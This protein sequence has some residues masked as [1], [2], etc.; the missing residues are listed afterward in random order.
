MLFEGKTVIVTG[1]S[2]GIGLATAR[3]FKKEGA[4]VLLVA[5]SKER[6]KIIAEEIDAK[7]IAVD[8]T[9]KDAAEKIVGDTILEWNRIDV[10]VNAAGIL[11]TG[12][13]MST[14][15]EDF[16]K[17]MDV[18]L[19]SVFLLMQTAIPFLKESKGNI[20]NVSSVTGIRAFPGILSY[21][22]SKAALDHLTRCSALD[23]AP[24]GIR[25]NAVN[26]GVVVTN[27]H[28]AGGM[29]E[30]SYSNFLEHS[31]MTHPL[32]RV[33]TPD[34]VADLILFLASEKALWITGETVSIDG[35]RFLT[36]LR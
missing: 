35:G 15:V 17:M 32:G 10:L 19:R 22:V 14:P 5:R 18:N 4:N 34:E 33:G 13:I 24:F 2:S 1:A 7:Y 26:P 11:E 30:E 29:N 3:A 28:R 23:L 8:V 20:I 16:D 12:N 21:C 9:D 25:V 6:L 27:L 36:C 31:K